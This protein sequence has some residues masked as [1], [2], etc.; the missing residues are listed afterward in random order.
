MV[1]NAYIH[2]P[3]CK[4]K[5]NYCSFTS[6]T[7]TSLKDIYINS[8]IKEIKS[9]YRQEMLDTL[10]FGG[11]TPSLM[12]PDD[13]KKIISHFKINPNTE[14]TVELNPENSDYDYLKAVRNIGI[15]RLSIGCQSFDDDILSNIGRKH[16]ASDTIK[17][18]QNAKSAGFD[19][20]NLDLIYGL[21][22]QTTEGFAD[23]LKKVSE[24]CPQHISL[25]GLKIEQGCKF[26]K[27]MPEN[28]PDEDLQAEMYLTA[29][30]ILSQKG[31]EH[32]EISNFSLAGYNSRH[33]LNYWNN[34][35]Y[36]GFGVA[37]HGFEGKTR[38]ANT[39]DI[40]QYIKN[41][42][43]GREENTLSEKQS[44]EEEIFLGFRKLCGINISD[45]NKKFGINFNEKYG[46]QLKKYLPDGF[47]TKT[48]DGYKLSLKGILV[49]NSILCDFLE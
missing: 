5:C 6:F 3:F 13:F 14:I 4:Q 9:R 42:L 11:G 20:I 47:L 36:Y 18:V 45:I 46:I 28:I 2:I 1:Q 40:K 22:N 41:P 30:K 32:Y 48:E 49:S 44:L 37:A 43:S 17:A 38:Y 15:N 8:L 26:Y 23:D 31:F 33:N 39:S 34:N 25:Y 35:H 12:T 7:D 19:N 29:V 16:K 10:Y 24:L 27:N 21:P